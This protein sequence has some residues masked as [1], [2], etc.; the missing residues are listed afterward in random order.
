MMNRGVESL[1]T[2]P[3]S[4]APN[5]THI[6]AREKTNWNCGYPRLGANNSN[7]GATNREICT[8]LAKAMPMLRSNP[9][10]PGHS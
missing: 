9:V 4:T 7:A 8:Q 6:L 5:R 1:Y 10:G 2:A 3:R